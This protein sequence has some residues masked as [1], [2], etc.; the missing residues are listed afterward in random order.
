MMLA[1]EMAYAHASFEFIDGAG[2]SSDPL[3]HVSRA[4][5]PEQAARKPFYTV[6]THQKVAQKATRCLVPN[7]AARRLESLSI[8]Q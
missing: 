5:P 1:N 8:V 6:S 2:L 7:G 3:A 4:T